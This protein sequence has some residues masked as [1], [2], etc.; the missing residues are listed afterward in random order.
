MGMVSILNICELEV[1][2]NDRFSIEH[3]IPLSSALFI[4]PGPLFWGE[5]GGV[6]W[7]LLCGYSA[8]CV[9]FIVFVCFISWLLF[10]VGLEEVMFG[11]LLT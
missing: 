4:S 7:G 6:C 1:H 11:R 3:F 2:V 8:I 10:A 9:N 5:G